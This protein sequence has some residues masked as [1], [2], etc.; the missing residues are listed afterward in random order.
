MV[1]GVSG[2]QGLTEVVSHQVPMGASRVTAPS[3]ESSMAHMPTTTL[4][5]EAT[6]SL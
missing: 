1:T 6:R 3:S 4:V 5:R 2:Y